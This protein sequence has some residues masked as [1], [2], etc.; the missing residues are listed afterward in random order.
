MNIHEVAKNTHFFLIQQIKKR[1]AQKETV[2]STAF[3]GHVNQLQV[4][5]DLT[6]H[7]A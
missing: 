1:T 4:S 2:K 7:Q 5:C 3:S 6:I